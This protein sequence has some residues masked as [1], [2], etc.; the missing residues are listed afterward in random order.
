M[1]SSE[2]LILRDIGN[3]YCF[4]I[5]AKLLAVVPL[6]KKSTSSEQIDGANHLRLKKVALTTG[7]HDLALSILKYGCL[8]KYNKYAIKMIN[9]ILN[10]ITI[11]APSALANNKIMQAGAKRATLYAKI[12]KILARSTPDHLII[13][14]LNKP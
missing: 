1:A 8:D 7:N 14:I 10:S 2:R 13:S 12:L 6:S 9:V 11:D 3:R 5:W 4:R